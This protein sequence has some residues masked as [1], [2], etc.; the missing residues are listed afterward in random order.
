MKLQGKWDKNFGTKALKYYFRNVYLTW[1]F[2]M[3]GNLRFW[4]LGYV[5]KVYLKDTKVLSHQLLKKKEL[6]V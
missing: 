1:S 2:Q 3:F 4:N 6:K 5:M